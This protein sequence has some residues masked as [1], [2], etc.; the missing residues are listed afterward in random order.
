MLSI[1]AVFMDK[2]TQQTLHQLDRLTNDLHA[3]QRRLERLGQ[4]RV[5][6]YFYVPPRVA[7]GFSVLYAALQDMKDQL[8]D[9][10]LHPEG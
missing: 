7:A 1:R 4:A 5:P 9:T 3:C 2:I 8:Q 10:S 6:V